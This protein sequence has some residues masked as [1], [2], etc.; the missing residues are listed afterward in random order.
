MWAG[1]GDRHHMLLACMGFS[2][3]LM[4]LLPKGDEGKESI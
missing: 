4:A 1:V 2:F 3:H